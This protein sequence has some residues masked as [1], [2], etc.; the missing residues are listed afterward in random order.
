[1]GNTAMTRRSQRRGAVAGLALLLIGSPAL[2]DGDAAV[3]LPGAHLHPESISVTDDGTAFVGSMNG[4]V[5]KVSLKTGKATQFIA[6]GAY[7]SGALYGVLADRRHGIVWT[8]T[9]DFPGTTV[10]VA[11]ADPGHWVKGFDLATGKG[12]ISLRLPGQ[13]AEC[14][15]FAAGSDGSV[16]IADSGLPQILRWR[17]GARKLEVWLTDSRLGSPDTRNGGMR[18]GG[19]DGIVFGTDGAIYINN[20]YTGALF[21]VP[22]GKHGRAGTAML[23]TD[24]LGLPDGMRPLPGGDMVVANARGRVLRLSVNGGAVTVT[25][26]VEGVFEPYAVGFWGGR[27][28]YTGAQFGALFAPD[29]VR[30]VLPFKLTPVRLPD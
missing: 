12:R 29:K 7:G 10:H 6:P 15:D 20:Y 22:V 25:P 17:P 27:V 1:M 19:L 11:G 26:L 3:A 4:G 5:L 21:R 2:A 13:H 24:K 9:N 14:N 18:G 8:C 16:Y 30:V 28:W 23:L